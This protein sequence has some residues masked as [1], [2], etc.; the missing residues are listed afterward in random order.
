MTVLVQSNGD[1][2]AAQLTILN[3]HIG[4]YRIDLWADSDG[5]GGPSAGDQFERTL[6]EY[7]VNDDVRVLLGAPSTLTKR[8]VQFVWVIRKD[9]GSA[10]PSK[11]K[12]EMW[13]GSGL[14]S[15]FPQEFE[16]DF[17]SGQ[18]HGVFQLAYFVKAG[19]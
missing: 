3:S 13:Q 18:N 5:S 19:T 8:T 16:V 14:L 2:V 1:A 9:P 11:V 7:K 4:T 12:L 17:P 15:G 6:K 10:L